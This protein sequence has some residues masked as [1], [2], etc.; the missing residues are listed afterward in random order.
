MTI[1]AWLGWGLFA[2]AIF[3]STLLLTLP[4]HLAA[5]WAGLPLTGAQGTLWH[6][7]AGLEI[8][9]QRIEHIEWRIHL[10]WPWQGPFGAELELRQQG[11]QGRGEAMLAWNGA[12]HVRDARLEGPLDSPVSS[13]MLPV[14]V[15]GQAHINLREA[16]WRNGLIRAEGAVLTLSAPS[17]RLDDWI[18]L[19]DQRAELEVRQGVL[20]GRLADL[21]G[22]LEV[23]GTLNGR[24]ASGLSLDARLNA[25]P[26]ASPTLAETLRLLPPHPQGGA[27]AKARF[28]APWLADVPS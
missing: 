2:L 22:P 27:G 1:R 12:L 10:L 19:G 17:I 23:H 4:A 15:R 21:G 7:S 5:R 16:V 8:G 28:A 11:W 6:G 14:P 25:R 24:L 9:A 20:D 26:H 13:R 18:A 3:L